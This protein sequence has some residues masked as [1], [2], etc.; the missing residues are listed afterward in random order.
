MFVSF[1]NKMKR[2]IKNKTK[3]AKPFLEEII[4]QI[5]RV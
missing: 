4:Y 3:K 1:V 5:V 2:I